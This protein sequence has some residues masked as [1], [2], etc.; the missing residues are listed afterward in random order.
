MQRQQAQGKAAGNEDQEG[1]LH[2]TG[3]IARGRILL[4]WGQLTQVEKVTLDKGVLQLAIHS[5]NTCGSMMQ[6]VLSGDPLNV[7]RLCR[8]S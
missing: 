4:G 8:W 1:K 5:A 7:Q 6:N 3:S 2:T